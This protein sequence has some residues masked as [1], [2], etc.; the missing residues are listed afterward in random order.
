M[1]RDES[2]TTYTVP[3]AAALLGLSDKGIYTSI[4]EGKFTLPHLIVGRRIVIPKKPL[5]IFLDPPH[6][7]AGA[8]AETAR[9][10]DC[11]A[12]ADAVKAAQEYME[13]MRGIDPNIAKK[14]DALDA[15]IKALDRVDRK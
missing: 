11:S 10:G 4:K 1:K 15:K 7:P 5:D 14:L 2:K 3:E 13:A 9:C 6:R 12:V 8:K